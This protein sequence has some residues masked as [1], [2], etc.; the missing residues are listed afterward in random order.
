MDI[1]AHPIAAGEP[2]IISITVAFQDFAFQC[3]LLVSLW[4]TNVQEV[5]LSGRK[6][7]RKRYFCGV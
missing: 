2:S 6:L 4:V 1:Y 3:A 5:L 7:T